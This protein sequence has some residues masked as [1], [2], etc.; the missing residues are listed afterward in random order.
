MD[1]GTI[2]GNAPADKDAGAPI[3]AFFALFPDNAARARLAALAAEV[4]RRCRGRTVLS[5]HVHLTLA[6]LGDV[7]G[8]EI[9]AL[10]AIGDALPKD[11]AIIEFDQLGAWRAS[12]VAWIAPSVVPA[13]VLSL[14]DR[15]GASLRRSGFAVDPR[16]FRPHVT[17]ARRCVQPPARARCAP[18]LWQVD[19]LCLIGSVLRPEGPVH[20]ELRAWPL[21]RAGP[22]GSPPR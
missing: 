9:E 16:P 4:A 22:P 7:P 21:E 10:C 6:F 20:R 18:I 2:T 17:L 19:R 1:H 5:E 8:T 14:H 3:R 13:P 11:G 12:G 15:L